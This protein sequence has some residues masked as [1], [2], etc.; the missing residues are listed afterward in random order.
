[1]QKGLLDKACRQ[2]FGKHRKDA[3]DVEEQS[4][5]TGANW[6]LQCWFEQIGCWL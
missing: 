4:I 1:M 3:L 2:C 6:K 5:D